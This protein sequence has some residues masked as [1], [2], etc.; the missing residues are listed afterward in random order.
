MHGGSGRVSLSFISSARGG[1]VLY[2]IRHSHRGSMWELG[3]LSGAC[4][5]VS[6]QGNGLGRLVG[7]GGSFA[8]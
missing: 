2:M 1:G 8:I 4:V 5:G 7:V 6:Y 3:F